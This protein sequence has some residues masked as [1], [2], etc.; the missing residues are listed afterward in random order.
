MPRKRGDVVGVELRQVHIVQG[1]EGQD[2]LA[3]AAAVEAPQGT[4]AH[5]DGLQGAHAEVVVALRGELLGAQLQGAHDFPSQ[6]LRLLKARGEQDNL[7]DHGVVRDHHSA[8][9]EERLQVVW[10]LGAPSV[11]WVHCD[12]TAQEGMSLISV[13]SKTKILFAHG[14]RAGWS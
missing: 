7:A 13:S 5:Q 12:V 6:Q 3:P 8:G 14:P 10:Q 11:A 2:H 1:R 9:P 4:R